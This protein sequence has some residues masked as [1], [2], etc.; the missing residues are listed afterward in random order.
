MLIFWN[1]EVEALQRG[2]ISAIQLRAPGFFV[3]AGVSIV[4]LIP[5]LFSNDALFF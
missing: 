3:G 5:S 1:I 2:H 4:V